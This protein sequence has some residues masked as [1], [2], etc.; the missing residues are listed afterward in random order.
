MRFSIFR[1]SSDLCLGTCICSQNQL[2]FPIIVEKNTVN[3]FDNK[4]LNFGVYRNFDFESK[5]FDFFEKFPFFQISNFR[6]FWKSGCYWYLVYS[7]P[8]FRF[9][10][11]LDL[12]FVKNLKYGSEY[13][14][15]REAEQSKSIKSDIR[16]G[17]KKHFLFF[18]FLTCL[19]SS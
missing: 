8:Y 12:W 7:F 3:W 1:K 10:T 19:H 13:E 11:N 6:F 17:K 2:F 16:G 14:C 9:F 15:P 5:I 18:A 4:T